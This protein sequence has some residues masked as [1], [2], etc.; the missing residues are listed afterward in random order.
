MSRLGLKPLSKQSAQQQLVAL[1]NSA[2]STPECQSAVHT[3]MQQL[4]EELQHGLN[5]HQCQ[6]LEPHLQQNTRR[7]AAM[8]EH[9]MDAAYRFY[10]QMR[11]TS[12]TLFVYLPGRAEI[13]L[14]NA[15]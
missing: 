12:D 7:H 15:P 10:L 2:G 14:D 3:L 9:V 11:G 13:P 5:T 8:L 4:K 1:R 6:D